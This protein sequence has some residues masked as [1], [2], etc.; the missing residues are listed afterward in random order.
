MDFITILFPL[1]S[2]MLRNAV[3]C[4]RYKSLWLLNMSKG[5]AAEIL[6]EINS[7]VL[8]C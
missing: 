3:I 4:V 8:L 7:G 6:T 2:N 5:E 1:I